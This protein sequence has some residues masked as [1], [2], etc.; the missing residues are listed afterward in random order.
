[1]SP[2][3]RRVRTGGRRRRG[4]VHP[5]VI[6]LVTILLTAFVTYYAFSQSLPFQHK[7]T[8]Y[9]VV[10]NSVNVRTDSPVRIAGIDVGSVQGTSPDGNATRITFTLDSSALPIHRDATIRIRDR[11]FLEGGYYLELDP[12]TPEAPD[13]HD[14]DTIPLSQTSTPVQFYQVLSTFDVAARASLRQLLDT[15]NQGFSPPPGRPLSDSGAGGFK[16]AIPQLTPVMKDVAW[17]SR[18]LHGTHPGEV[19]TLLSSASQ[20]T[21]TLASASPQL[22]DLVTSL[23]RTS[24]ALASTDGALAQSVAGLD[25]TLQVA[26][27]ALFAVDRALPPLVNLAIALDPSLKV[28]PPIL[29]ALTGTVTQLAS[30]LAPPE[31][32]KLLTSL[33]ATF[34]QFP[35]LLTELS[36]AFPIGKLVTD[37]L[38]THITPVIN[39]QVP[40]GPLS[41]GRPVWQDFVHFLPNV[42][43]ATGSFDA[44]GP[45]T[46][47]L[48]GGGPNTLTGGLLASLPVIGTII[49]TAPPGSNSLSGARPTW[50][51]DLKPSDFRP[52][53]PCTSDKVPS[54]AAPAHAADLVAERAAAPRAALLASIA[55]ALGAGATQQVAP[56][57][58]ARSASTPAVPSGSKAGTP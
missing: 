42:A 53:V 50:V 57:S 45:Y 4:R 54:L 30:V 46:R 7:Y 22:A 14:G 2:Q 20:V 1:M 26:P 38:Q 35:A 52:D 8:L 12:G 49:G 55:S 31:R 23:N 33:R 16:T 58:H 17:I 24:S 43:G 34:E 51:G 15:L 11:L 28:A 6:A 32:G 56:G 9:A 48:A 29:D 13:L 44:N 37:C 27:S 36:K 40:D 21:G 41:T 25:Q 5:L 18:A 3:P 10:N 39:R 47:T 19:E